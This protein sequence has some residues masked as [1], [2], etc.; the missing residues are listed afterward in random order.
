M[1]YTTSVSTPLYDF[2]RQGAS[3]S[4]TYRRPLPADTYELPRA[5]LRFGAESTYQ[6]SFRSQGMSAESYLKALVEGRGY[7]APERMRGEYKDHE[8]GGPVLGGATMTLSSMRG[9]R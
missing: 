9:I 6:G 1:N 5:P 3:I 8:K 2:S 4:G 7:H